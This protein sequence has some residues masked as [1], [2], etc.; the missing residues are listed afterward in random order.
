MGYVEVCLELPQIAAFHEDVLMLVIDDSPYTKRVP[1][2]KGT[3][4]TDRALALI[5]EE[6]IAKLGR[7]WHRGHLSTLLTL[8]LAQVARE[9][10]K[11][12][13]FDLIRVRVM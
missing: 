5:T 9:M 8:K 1:V 6:E 2:V 10:E 12:E 7:A 11:E 3:L 13:L 4:H